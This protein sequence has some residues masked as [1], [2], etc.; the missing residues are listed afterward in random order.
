MLFL[1]PIT[2]TTFLFTRREAETRARAREEEAAARSPSYA[3]EGVGWLGP[4]GLP[5]HSEAHIHVV[6]LMI[7]AEWR[8]VSKSAFS[9]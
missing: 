5:T 1:L 4:A 9:S 2:S 3:T 7:D 8:Y 6:R